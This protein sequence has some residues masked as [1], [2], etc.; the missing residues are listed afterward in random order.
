[1][2]TTSTRQSPRIS[3]T[4]QKQ[5][6][7]NYL[8]PP[9][10]E[11]DLDEPPPSAP[12]PSR[13]TTRQNSSNDLD[14]R[15][16]PRIDQPSQSQPLPST[17]KS[18]SQPSSDKDPSRS[19]KRDRDPSSKDQDKRAQSSDKERH[20]EK[21]R[22]REKDRAR[23][24]EKE[25]DRAR[26]KKHQQQQDALRQRTDQERTSRDNAPSKIPKPF[27]LP[28]KAPA[29]IASTPMK[30]PQPHISKHIDIS[31]PMPVAE[32]PQIKANKDLRKTRRS[33]VGNRGKRSSSWS[34]SGIIDPPHPDLNSTEFC[35][36]IDQDLPD[37]RRFRI[38]F[39]WCRFRACNPDSVRPRRSKRVEE[40]ELKEQKLLL[41]AINDNNV[42]SLAQDIVQDWVKSLSINAPPW[43]P[44]KTNK[45]KQ[46]AKN[47]ENEKYKELIKKSQETMAKLKQ[48][49][50]MWT[51]L[52]SDARK[53]EQ[54][55]V[56]MYNK[57]ST[58]IN[59][60]DTLQLDSLPQALRSD[61]EEILSKSSS[62]HQ[63][64][65]QNKS[66]NSLNFTIAELDQLYHQASTYLETSELYTD[67]VMSHFLGLL[68]SRLSP[69][70]NDDDEN[71]P[72]QE[73]ALPSTLNLAA[74][75][76]NNK[77]KEADALPLLRAISRPVVQ[78]TK[79]S[80]SNDDDDDRAGEISLFWSRKV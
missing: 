9:L 40:S 56:E 67:N 38:L 26:A 66:I 39:E 7:F 43:M 80:N 32:T 23:E 41:N 61:V 73:K 42:V 58:Q 15:K 3:N 14:S 35:R 2:A 71:K 12:L 53:A 34:R 70:K 22:E 11:D 54:E 60:D 31:A 6:S 24:K 57:T 8:L 64:I 16:K 37:P 10:D 78:Q 47:P 72:D 52:R 74:A 46:K 44:P 45:Q 18:K 36:H 55:S 76:S 79:K 25:K 75:N 5:S 62:D 17:H 20:K 30:A 1:M 33:S 29:T 48:E 65:D 68:R 51:K 49:D 69:N 28:E 19:H 77:Y 50:E 4:L 59:Q 13:R 63:P 21:E 27:K